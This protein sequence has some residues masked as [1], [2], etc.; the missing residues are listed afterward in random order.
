MGIQG[1]GPLWGTAHL[2]PDQA[3]PPA[4]V[5]AQVAP[6]VPEFVENVEDIVG[7]NVDPPK[8]AVGRKENELP[9]AA[10]A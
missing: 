10:D 9:L 5:M 2:G 8:H 3:P 7:H 1:S 4:I 6:T